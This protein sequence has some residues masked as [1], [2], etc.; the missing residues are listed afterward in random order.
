MINC[1]PQK[2]P[3]FKAV[4]LLFTRRLWL[5]IHM[6]ELGQPTAAQ[7]LY[8]KP[9][10]AQPLTEEVIEK[11]RQAA[12]EAQSVA[13]ALESAQLALEVAQEP[14]QAE[15]APQPKYSTRYTPP[16]KNRKQRRAE[17]KEK[18]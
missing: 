1:Y 15:Q 14:R 3:F 2:V 5:A 9:K 11:Q 12:Q 7:V 17:R 6:S 13:L 4:K 8:D 10:G 16:P 18:K